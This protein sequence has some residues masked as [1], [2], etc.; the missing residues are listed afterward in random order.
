MY[1]QAAGELIQM[2][3]IKKR[4]EETLVSQ[5][6]QKNETL[7]NYLSEETNTKVI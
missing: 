4:E 3:E 7:Q 5:I 6:K 1:L 2:N